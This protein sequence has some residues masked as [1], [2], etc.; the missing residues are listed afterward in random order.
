MMDATFTD[1]EVRLFQMGGSFFAVEEGRVNI[2]DMLDLRAGGI[3]RCRGNPHEVLRVV[4][5]E[6]GPVGCVAGWISEDDQ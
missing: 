4:Q 2:L 1:K 3:V 6:D 5:V